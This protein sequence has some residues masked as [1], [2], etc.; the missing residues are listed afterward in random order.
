[1]TQIYDFKD[2]GAYVN[3]YLNTCQIVFQTYYKQ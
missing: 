1:M 3:K 2:A